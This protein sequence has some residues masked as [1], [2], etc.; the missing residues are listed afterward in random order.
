MVG[1][2]NNTVKKW[3][4]INGEKKM[5]IVT[6]TK[7]YCASALGL[8]VAEWESLSA[9]MGNTTNKFQIEHF[10]KEMIKLRD[11][12]ITVVMSDKITNLSAVGLFIRNAVI[13]AVDKLHEQNN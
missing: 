13:K 9:I 12:G 8:T 3:Q 4:E 11:L 10:I 6:E 1:C 7:L 2:L 5:N